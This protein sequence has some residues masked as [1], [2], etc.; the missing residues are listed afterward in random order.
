MPFILLIVAIIAI[1]VM[2][3]VGGWRARRSPTP[4]EKTAL[5]GDSGVGSTTD[6]EAGGSL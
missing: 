5:T 6:P 4:E 3:L 2:A 1:V